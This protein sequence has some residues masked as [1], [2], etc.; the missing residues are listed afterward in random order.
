[1]A[2]NQPASMLR[3]ELLGVPFAVFQTVHLIIAKLHICGLVDGEVDLPFGNSGSLQG[4][5]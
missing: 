4:A 3:L 5:P 1:M 2:A